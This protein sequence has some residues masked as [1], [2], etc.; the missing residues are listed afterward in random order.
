MA[1]LI[2]FT[3]LKLQGDAVFRLRARLAAVL[4][5]L[6]GY[7]P[8]DLTG[9]QVAA[10]KRLHRMWEWREILDENFDSLAVVVGDDLLYQGEPY[11]RIA[12]PG[13]PD[14]NIGIH[15]DTHYGAS[16]AE[17]V[18]W[19]PL[20]EATSGAEMRI[21]PRSHLEPE[22]AFPWR[23]APAACE[24]GSERHWLGFRYAPKR[25]SPEVEAQALPVACHVGEAIL[26][27]SACVHG[28]VVNAA[29]WTRISMDIRLV[30]AKAPIQ[31]SR[32]LHGD[33]YR[34]LR[35]PEVA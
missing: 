23:Q 9:A 24:R 26:F 29:P 20:T 14:D 35:S 11:L 27:N 5:D 4:G 15:R 31:R 10:T 22:E 33:L 8:D 21:L 1:R 25:M 7:R 30:D 17:W 32:G 12:R 18:L 34:P 28:Q 16:A 19:V 13:R 6:E 3:V 2:G